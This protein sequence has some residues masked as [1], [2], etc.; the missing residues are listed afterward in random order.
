VVNELRSKGNLKIKRFEHLFYNNYFDNHI[1][2]GIFVKVKGKNKLQNTMSIYHRGILTTSIF[3]LLE[4]FF[5]IVDRRN[6][7]AIIKSHIQVEVPGFE[8]RS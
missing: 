4:K 2:S 6:E 5:F 1:Y 3:R 7:K 8:P